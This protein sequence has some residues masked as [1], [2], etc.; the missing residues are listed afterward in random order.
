MSDELV[1]RLRREWQSQPHDSEQVLR[2]LRSQR[3]RPHLTLGLEILG[4]VIAMGVGVW[5]A[6]VAAHQVEHQLLFGVSAA[7]LLITAP[8]LA[9]ATV[10]A[11][12]PA[13]AWHDETPASVLRIGRR[14][15]VSSLLAMRVGRW[16]IG[17]IVVFVATL[18]ILQW[19]GLIDANGFLVLYSSVC[20]VVSLGSW[21][22]MQWRTKAVIA[23]RE[24]CVSLLAMLEKA[25]DEEG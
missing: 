23:E 3:W 16:H 17:V 15:A 18:W 6:W 1:S 10:L 22:W 5:F 13:L 25:D 2:R 24:A 4:C 7:I 21:V 8:V 14:R 11:R 20:L 9:V 12:R 19:L